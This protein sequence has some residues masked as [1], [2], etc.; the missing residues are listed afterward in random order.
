MKFSQ[1]ITLKHILIDD[2]KFIGLQFYANKA[3]DI[4]VKEL[5]D[6]KWSEEFNMYYVP[7]NKPNLDNIYN[8]F[9]GVAWIDS[10]Y[11]FQHT[12]SKQLDETFNIDWYRKRG[13]SENYKYCPESY[14]QKLEL[15]KYANNTVKSYIK[16][17]EAFIN[18]YYDKEID[19]LNENDIREYLQVLTQEKRSNSYNN[20]A[21]NSIKF[22]YEIV[23]GMPNRLYRIERPRVKMK[24]PVVLAKEDIKR[25]INCTPNI[26][27]RCVVS[28]LYS[29]G[30]RRSELLN[31][32]I[33]DIDSS[34]MLIHVKDA[35]G[36]KERYTLLSKNTLHDLRTY[37]KQWKP[38]N[39]LFE[40]PNKDKYSPNSVG[41][42]VT[43]AAIKAKIRKKVSAHILR[44]S[45]ATHLLEAGTD[46]RYI[47]ILLGHSSTKT[48]EIYTHVAK[49]SF[50]SIKNPL[51]L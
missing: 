25:M 32:Q 23:L 10:K 18:H 24:L 6:I 49:S 3:L 16:A 37:Y 42:I 40:S 19:H 41:K 50:D 5:Q 29:A 9:K 30:L 28:L 38:T 13:K 34:R 39:Y 15:K 51:D 20:I 48:T 44:H 33:S 31:L 11:F 35:K 17:F 21:I 1:H 26:K 8:I 45:F 22:Y 36:N 27:H 43:T 47:Q 12:R 2:K 46:I 4:L 14:L 7:N